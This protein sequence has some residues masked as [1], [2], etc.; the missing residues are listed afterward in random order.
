MFGLDDKLSE[1][2]LEQ[3]V[4]DVILKPAKNLKKKE[5]Q[6]DSEKPTD[7]KPLEKTKLIDK[8]CVE[9]SIVSTIE[10]V[11]R[12]E[13]INPT[14]TL[15]SFILTRLKEETAPAKF[16]R[17]R[18]KSALE[19]EVTKTL[20]KDDTVQKISIKPVPSG[21]VRA[22][23]G[24]NQYVPRD[25]EMPSVTVAIITGEKL[26][27]KKM[28]DK[29]VEESLKPSHFSGQA[30]VRNPGALAAYL[31]R[32][33]MEREHGTEE[34]AKKFKE[35]VMFGQKRSK[36]EQDFSDKLEAGEHITT[37]PGF[38]PPDKR[39]LWMDTWNTVYDRQLSKGK[40]AQQ[41]EIVAYSVATKMVQDSLPG[42]AF[43][44]DRECLTRVA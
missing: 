7:K 6:P 37:P 35:K 26:G 12:E 23:G 39:T 19:Q 44:E 10:E 30:G 13:G 9:A 17:K 33:K 31:G 2:I 20:P 1:L 40:S 42:K 28:I 29:K 22:P 38:I 4:S 36:H 24:V 5:V 3:V 27:K 8:K 41:A 25:T 32:K 21:K 16:M 14:K 18:A 15:T 34:G 43:K 11:L